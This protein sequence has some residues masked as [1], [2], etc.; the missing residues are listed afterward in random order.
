MDI[1]RWISRSSPSKLLCSSSIQDS[2]GLQHRGQRSG[3]PALST[4][5]QALIEIRTL[6]RRKRVRN[7]TSDIRKQGWIGKMACSLCT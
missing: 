1:F 5:S 4:G 3:S 2:L 6:T 7:Q